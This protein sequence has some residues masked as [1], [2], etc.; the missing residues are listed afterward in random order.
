MK[1]I[2]AGLLIAGLGMLNAEAGSLTSAMDGHLVRVENKKVVD[3][4]AGH[5][6]DKKVIAL[7]FTA[8]WCGPCRVFTPKLVKE[9]ARLAAEHPEFELV[10]VSRDENAEKM[11][12]YMV[13]AGMNFPALVFGADQKIPVLGRL[14]AEGIPYLVVVDA[15]GKELAGRGKA[16]WIH[17]EEVLPKLRK[18]LGGK[19]T[20]AAM[21]AQ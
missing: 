21:V 3:V 2:L 7:Y 17:P 6:K 16:R 19:K 13:S 8:Q 5:L 9:Y 11:K 10:M 20:S 14:E 4:P 18:V 12:R 15:N 1:I